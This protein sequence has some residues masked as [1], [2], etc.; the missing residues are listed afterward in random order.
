MATLEQMN[1]LALSI[2]DTL[3]PDEVGE[4]TSILFDYIELSYTPAEVLEIK[5]RLMNE[6]VD[7]D[8]LCKKKHPPA[9]K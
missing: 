9:P 5:A 2:C 8:G 4:F 6:G 3:A 7:V 1:D